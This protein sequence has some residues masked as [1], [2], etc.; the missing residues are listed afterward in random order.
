MR[1]KSAKNQTIWNE[2]P[3]GGENNDNR[4]GKAIL[5]SKKD[6]NVGLAKSEGIKIKC[7]SYLFFAAF[8]LDNL[9]HSP[10]NDK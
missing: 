2:S 4:F 6:E 3:P 1:I 9:F 7:Q 8:Y 5:E 10:S